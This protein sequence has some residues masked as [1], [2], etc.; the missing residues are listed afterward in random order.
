MGQHLYRLAIAP[1]QQHGDRIHLT[2]DQQ[3]YLYRV[4]RLTAGDRCIVINGRGKAWIAALAEDW[5][6]LLDPLELGTELPHPLTL[7]VALPKGSG[8]EDIIRSGTELGVSRFQ[9]VISDRTLLKPSPQK[10]TRWQ[11]IAQEAAEQSERAIVPVVHDPLPFRDSLDPGT[12]TTALIALAR[13]DSPP[14][15]TVL[16]SLPRSGAELAIATG[17]EG[18]WTPEE[19]AAAIAAGFLPVSLG[20]RILRAVTAPVAAAATIAAWQEQ[21]RVHPVPSGEDSQC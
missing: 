12:Q 3:H 15:T 11:R 20:R 4:L 2:P 9:P 17:P 1:M 6:T 13:G 5:A 8:F 19:Q 16:D 10:L 18:G 7:I 14:L 21:N